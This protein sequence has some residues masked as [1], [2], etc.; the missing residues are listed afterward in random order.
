[1]SDADPELAPAV[2]PSRFREVFAQ[3]AAHVALVAVRDE[4][5]VYGTTVTSLTPVAADPPTVLVSLGASAQVLPFLQPGRSWVVSL[6]AREQAPLAE[7]FA[8]SFPVGPSPFPAQGDPVVP[9]SLGH[10][11]CR[12]TEVVATEAGSRLVLGRVVEA[13]VDPERAP[14]LYRR[15][16][17]RALED[18]HP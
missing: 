15:R 11:I 18:E 3:W 9:G 1:M 8:D 12:V 4:G 13:E 5:Q 17:Y 16:R 6:L 2:S 10:L 14:L 7:A